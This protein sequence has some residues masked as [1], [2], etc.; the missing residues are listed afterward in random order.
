MSLVT[1]RRISAPWGLAGGE[2]GSPGEN[3]LLPS[4][5]ETRAERLPDKSRSSYEPVTFCES[6]PPAGGWGNPPIVGET[7]AS[8]FSSAPT[9]TP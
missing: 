6:S 3:L 1:E 7:A 4:G 9:L 2:P 5:D 8:D